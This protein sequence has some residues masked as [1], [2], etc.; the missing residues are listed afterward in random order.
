MKP[1]REITTVLQGKQGGIKIDLFR[2]MPDCGRSAD[3]LIVAY[4]PVNCIRKIE[5]GILDGAAPIVLNASLH[6]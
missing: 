4:A 6:P 1:G 3:R 5:S 2:H